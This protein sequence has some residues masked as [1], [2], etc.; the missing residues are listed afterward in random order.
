MRKAVSGFVDGLFLTTIRQTNSPVF[1]VIFP[2]KKLK[3]NM[4]LGGSQHGY[5]YI[6]I[7]ID[8][9]IYIYYILGHLG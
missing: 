7:Y 3:H 1:F 6:Y 8:I 9:Y 4:N 5:R 2:P